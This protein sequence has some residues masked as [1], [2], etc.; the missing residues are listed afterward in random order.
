ML[1]GKRCI[2]LS[3]FKK[4]ETVCIH[5]TSCSF[6]ALKE[7]LSATTYSSLIEL[8]LLWFCWFDPQVSPLTSIH[9]IHPPPENSHPLTTQGNR[10]CPPHFNPSF[11]WLPDQQYHYN[12][13][14]WNHKHLFLSLRLWTTAGG[15]SLL[16][17]LRTR[18]GVTTGPPLTPAGMSG[19]C[20]SSQTIKVNKNSRWVGALNHKWAPFTLLWTT[21]K[22]KCENGPRD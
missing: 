10:R 22:Y 8:H 2:P 17:Q 16:I 3:Q 6:C 19:S 12:W 13:I 18:S 5:P 1:W 14:I 21:S 9:K 20:T 7:T 15:L 4:F 11:D